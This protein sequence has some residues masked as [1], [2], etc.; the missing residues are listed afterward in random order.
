MDDELQ[1]SLGEP[2]DGEFCRRCF[3]PHRTA[4]CPVDPM[5]E[6]R[7]RKTYIDICKSG[8]F[9]NF[10]GTDSENFLKWLDTFE[11]MVLDL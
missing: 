4:R 1:A 6:S 10:K 9:D 8:G 11:K 5:R 7:R 2:P 3:G